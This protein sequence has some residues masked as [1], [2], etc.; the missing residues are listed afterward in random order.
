[1]GFSQILGSKLGN[2]IETAELTANSVTYAKL[3]DVHKWELLETLEPSGVTTITSTG[4]LTAY[5]RYKVIFYLTTPEATNV[6]NVSIRFNAD[7]TAIY[8]NQ[9]I[10]GT[11]VTNVQNTNQI[12]VSTMFDRYPAIGNIEFNGVSPAHANGE[13]QVTGSGSTSAGATYSHK[14][15]AGEYTI[16][17]AQQITSITMISDQDGMTGTIQIY[18]SAL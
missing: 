9:Y 18:G 5:T 7:A 8:S 13:I 2:T 10:A 6:E 3:G 4:T 14:F 1:M 17:N 12:R 16:G 11:T 15:M